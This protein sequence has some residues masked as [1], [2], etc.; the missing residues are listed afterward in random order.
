MVTGLRPP[1]APRH[2]PG[3][4]SSAITSLLQ[5]IARHAEQTADTRM[6]GRSMVRLLGDARP[7]VCSLGRLRCRPG[8][9]PVNGT[10]DSNDNPGS[11]SP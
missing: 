11:G 2:Q 10:T 1:A 3:R 4:T 7:S 9:P 8:G 5:V 6:T